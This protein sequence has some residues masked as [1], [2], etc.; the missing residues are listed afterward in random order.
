[1]SSYPWFLFIPALL[2]NLVFIPLKVT[3][4][5]TGIEI[6]QVFTGQI[7]LTFFI[8]ISLMWIY[9]PVIDIGMGIH[10]HHPENPEWGFQKIDLIDVSA[11]FIVAGGS[12]VLFSSLYPF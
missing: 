1:M 12:V 2:A 9:A 5:L 10:G 7:Y 4:I 8:L 11:L 6:S 3:E